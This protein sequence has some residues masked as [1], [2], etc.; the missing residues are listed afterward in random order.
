M[1][2]GEHAVKISELKEQAS[3]RDKLIKKLRS[4]QSELQSGLNE[5]SKELEV[6][7]NEIL[8]VRSE[9]NQTLK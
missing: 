5:M 8:R 9:A 1:Q 3:S 6:K 7:V 2:D 4:E